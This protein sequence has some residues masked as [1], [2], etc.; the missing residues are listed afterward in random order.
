MGKPRACIAAAGQQPHQPDDNFLH[1]GPR[2][3]QP[4]LPTLPFLSGITFVASTA[5]APVSAQTIVNP[6]AAAFEASAD[7]YATYSDGTPI[8]NHYEMDFYL[9]GASAPFQIASIGKPTPDGTGT[10]Y[11]SFASLFSTPLAAGQTY[12]ADVA[13]VGPGGRAAS[14]VSSDSFAVTSCTVGVSQLNASMPAAGGTVLEYVTTN[15]GCGWTAT[16]SAT[17]L[18]I[19]SGGTGSGNGSVTMAAAANSALTS[20]SAK[21]SVGGQTVAVTQ[22]AACGYTASPSTVKMT[23]SGSPTSVTITAPAGCAWSAT[24]NAAWLTVAGGSGSGSGSVTLSA[25]PNNTAKTRTTTVTV[26]GTTVSVT[27]AGSKGKNR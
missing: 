19:T 27:E 3:S 10:I 8:V 25:T 26:G 17:W 7:H 6:T 4:A 1:G 12:T 2:G 11:V 22:A 15:P 23:A 24:N 5:V 9:I 18:S 13:A 20:R 21:M 16:T 14:S